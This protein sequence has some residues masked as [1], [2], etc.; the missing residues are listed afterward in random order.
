LIVSTTNGGP[1]EAPATNPAPQLMVLAQYIKD[2]SFENPNAPGSL[3]QSTQPQINISVNVVTNPLSD[4]DIEVTLRTEGKA[5]ANGS[6]MFNIELDFAGVFRVQNVPLEQV[7][8][9]VLIECPRILFPFAREIIATSVRNGGFPPLLLDP[10][11]FVA[12]Y[13]QRLAQQQPPATA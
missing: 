7:Q 1:A 12:L 6:V 2:L 9:L 5:E 8:Q 13:Q 11:D 10:I 3:Q 4:T